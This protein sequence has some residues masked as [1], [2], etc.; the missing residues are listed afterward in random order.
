MTS[1]LEAGNQNLDCSSDS[2]KKKNLRVS[3][4]RASP[5]WKLYQLGGT[6]EN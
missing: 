4:N 1:A 3:T 5:E 2:Q 6:T